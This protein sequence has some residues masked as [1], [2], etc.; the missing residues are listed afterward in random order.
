MISSAES[1]LQTHSGVL[2]VTIELINVKQDIKN[3]IHKIVVEV[4]VFV[5][6]GGV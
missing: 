1:Y 4:L 6:D 3:E 5:G 2:P